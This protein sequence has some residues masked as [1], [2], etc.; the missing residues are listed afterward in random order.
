MLDK[1]LTHRQEGIREAFATMLAFQF[2]LGFLGF[3]TSTLAARLLGPAGR[4]ELAA[5]W[6]IPNL[7]AVLGGLGMGEASLYF[8]AKQPEATR[9]IAMESLRIAVYGATATL[10]IG[11]AVLEYVIEDPVTRLSAQLSLPVTFAVAVFAVCHQP[12]RALGYSRLWG[13]YRASIAGAWLFI[14]AAASILGYHNIRGIALTYVAAQLAIAAWSTRLI[15]RYSAN[16]APTWPRFRRR[17]LAY[18]LPSSMISVPYVLNANLDQV[19]MIGLVAR[20]DLGI[21]T[22]GVSFSLVAGFPFQALAKVTMPR[23]AAAG[24]AWRSIAIRLLGACLGLVVVTLLVAVPL[25]GWVF[26]AVMGQRFASG[27]DAARLLIL[28]ATIRGTADVLQETVRGLGTPVRAVLVETT[29]LFVGILA[30]LV[31]I[32]QHGLVGAAVASVL[33]Y[34][35]ALLGHGLLVGLALGR[36]RPVPSGDGGNSAGPAS[37]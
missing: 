22:A 27:V 35:T 8:A 24:D 15:R 4:G 21:Y 28:A 26:T 33:G 36:R 13:S 19:L 6:S 11:V 29:G 7:L 32:D 37:Q 17:L 10:L 16:E 5:V 20:A 18:G 25:T 1:A 23:I 14:L 9:R 3:L 31:L 30:L 2:A 34:G 12:L